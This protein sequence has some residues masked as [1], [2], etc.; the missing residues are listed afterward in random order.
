MK[1]LMFTFI[2]MVKS[3]ANPCN[4]AFEMNYRVKSAPEVKL[5]RSVFILDEL[6]KKMKSGFKGI[7]EIEEALIKG[8][9]NL[10]IQKWTHVFRKVQV[11]S[12][13]IDN[14]KR[15]ID[16]LSK[17]NLNLSGGVESYLRSE[18]LPQYI[19]DENIRD[20]VGFG[21]DKYLK[22]LRKKMDKY[23][24]ILGNNYNQYVDA[25]SML[26]GLRSEKTCSKSCKAAIDK[27]IDKTS[28]VKNE[29]RMHYKDI[30]QNR[31]TPSVEFIRSI[32]EVNE[33]A[34][35]VSK[36][37]LF[38]NHTF[39]QLKKIFKNRYII[40]KF[41]IKNSKEGL[42]TFGF[43]MKLFK[44]GFNHRY[45]NVHKKLILKISYSD[46]PVLKKLE[47]LKKEIGDLDFDDLL[48][49]FSRAVDGRVQKTFDDML[50]ALNTKIDDSKTLEKFE[51]AIEVGKKL[52][53]IGKNKP[54]DINWL[55]GSAL[56]AT[57]SYVYFDYSVSDDFSE[58]V[59]EVNQTSNSL[60]DDDEV[61]VIEVEFGSTE[62]NG[63]FIEFQEVNS[64]IHA[65]RE[66]V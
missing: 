40:R 29:Y 18:G 60:E 23:S 10:A 41:L 16:A 26:I 14:I 8:K 55:I 2:F 37:K 51:S 9:S 44:R 11:S 28:V 17:K 57:G 59:D 7:K 56:L 1:A 66:A 42:A 58:V 52:G 32:F 5:S 12:I 53:K 6:T 27:T 35:L 47:A 39:S 31:R 38:L 22:N 49:D 34:F 48:A 63:R 13:R 64:L 43:V 19:I 45:H 33:K 65:L 3:F 4:F 24:K 50:E 62:D 36:R 30:V 21:K 25:Q 61:E 20:I 46:L 15:L 54:K